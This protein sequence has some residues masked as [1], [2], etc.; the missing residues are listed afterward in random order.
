MWLLLSALALCGMPALCADVC[1]GL[2]AEAAK[3]LQ[4]W[5]DSAENPPPVS[6]RVS[7]KHGGPA[8]RITVRSRLRELSD[9]PVV[10]GYIEVARCR[11]AKQLQ[12]LPI[13]ADQPI[14]FGRTFHVEDLNFDGYLD[15]SVLTEFAA[16]FVSRSYWVYDPASGLF[17]ENDLTRK[18]GENCLGS[19][20]HGGCWKASEIDFDQ[21]TREIRA[22]YLPGFAVCSLSSTDYGGDRYRV[23]NNHLILIHKEEVTSDNCKVTYSD[24]AGG[25]MRVTGIRRFTAPPPS[26]EAPPSQSPNSRE[27]PSPISGV[28]L[29]ERPL[30]PNQQG[31]FSNTGGQVGGSQFVFPDTVDITGIRWYGYYTCRINPVGT[32]PVFNVSFLPDSGGLPVSEPIYSRQVQA[33]VSETTARVISD[34]AFAVNYEVYVYT[35]DALPPLSIPAGRRTWISI[36]AAPSSCEW[37]WN[38]GSAGD[39]GTSAWGASEGSRVSRWTQLSDNLAFALYGRKIGT[40]AH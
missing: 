24:L 2:P 6:F 36:S 29:Y 16:K 39:T 35:I 18:L 28:L 8:F 30:D 19:E 32:S 12:S 4:Y 38:R 34:P 11:D 7:V 9:N 31:L 26:V 13:M 10:A 1:N 33:R 3:G 23:N 22:H 14:N 25:T 40:V 17:V 27:P 5:L 37:L 15:F 20:W 21:N